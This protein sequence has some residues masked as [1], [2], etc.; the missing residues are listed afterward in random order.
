MKRSREGSDCVWIWVL[1]GVGGKLFYDLAT[2]KVISSGAVANR[3]KRGPRMWEIG[4][5]DL[6]IDTRR[7]LARQ[8]VLL[9]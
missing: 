2:S 4:S 1:H 5:L 6:K 7:F 8:L 3:V 9:G